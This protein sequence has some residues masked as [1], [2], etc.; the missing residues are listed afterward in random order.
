MKHLAKR[1]FIHKA[2]N[3]ILIVLDLLI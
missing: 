3:Y 2:V 1:L